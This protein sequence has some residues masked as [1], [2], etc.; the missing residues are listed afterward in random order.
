MRFGEL[1]SIAEGSFA[2]F[3]ER[4]NHTSVTVRSVGV[5]IKNM[6]RQ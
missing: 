6:S 3:T 1:I 5:V 2:N 4:W